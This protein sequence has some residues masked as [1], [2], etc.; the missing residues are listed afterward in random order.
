MNL[1]DHRTGYAE[2]EA[3]LDVADAW[4]GWID[5]TQPAQLDVARARIAMFTSVELSRLQT[6]A[7]G[8]AGLIESRMNELTRTT[9]E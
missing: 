2:T 6:I 5:D 9:D 3:L 7:L 8:L 1:P 4:D